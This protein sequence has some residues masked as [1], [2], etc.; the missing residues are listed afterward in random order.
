MGNVFQEPT[1]NREGLLIRFIHV[2]HRTE[3]LCSPLKAE[4]YIVSATEETS[5]PKWHLAHTTWFFE[6]FILARHI[7]SYEPFKPEYG[8]LFNS[9][10][11]SLGRYIE[12]SRRRHL[13]RPAID[14]IFQYRKE[15]TQLIKSLVE[16][17][18]EK[19]FSKFKT[20]LELGINHEEQHQEL[21]LMDIKRNFYENPL[22]PSYQNNISSINMMGVEE[23][24]WHNLPSG[25]VQIGQEKNGKEFA[26]DNEKDRFSYW[27]ESCMISSHLVTNDEYLAFMDE[28]GYE[29]SRLWLSDGWDIKEKEQWQHPLYWEKQ[30]QKWW[31]M[32][33]SGM[34]PLDL[35]A[36]VAHISYYEAV[37]FAQWK[38]GRLPNEFEWE[39]SAKM[40]TK[41]SHF[42]EDEEFEPQSATADYDL[43]SQIH[44]TLW[45]W[46][47][48]AFLPYPRYEKF[49]HGAGEY[50]DKFMCNQ[51]VLRGGACITPETHYRPTY[52]NFYYPHM[53]WQ[54]SGL[55]LAKDLT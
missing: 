41:R 33:L 36:P 29:N 11:R 50:N 37:A 10:Y 21:L 2:R 23:P 54:F 45:E 46:T 9:Y 42:L 28:G 27:I 48:S 7:R 51:M 34:A 13:S 31:V 30:G 22:R 24:Q 52:R 12:K 44:G 17:S 43:F 25:L 55:R 26:F 39:T 1:S 4:D 49:Q 3:H 6:N 47:Q 40:E 5:P 15:I 8:F 19:Q 16:N 38:G 32:T 18:D 35:S 20:M 53:R 14:E